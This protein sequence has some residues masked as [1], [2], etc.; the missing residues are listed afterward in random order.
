MGSFCLS[1]LVVS[2]SF[3]GRIGNTY[4]GEYHIIYGLVAS[5]ACRTHDR[6]H[7]GGMASERNG[8]EEKREAPVEKK[9]SKEG[10][11]DDEGGDELVHEYDDEGYWLEAWNEEGSSDEEGMWKEGET[12]IEREVYKKV[13]T[14]WEEVRPLRNRGHGKRTEE[15]AKVENEYL[16]LEQ[17]ARDRRMRYLST[18]F[19][20]AKQELYFMGKDQ[21]MEKMKRAVERGRKRKRDE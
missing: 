6:C 15:E 20:R 11:E 16:G 1:G 19:E 8:K 3:I 5:L 12:R 9:E 18:R 2:L 14:L 4:S 7:T 13:M 17:M 10:Q 21:D